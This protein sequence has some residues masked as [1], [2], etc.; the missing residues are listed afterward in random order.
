MH[1][2]VCTCVC[3]CMSAC[4]CICVCAR[5]YVC[6]CICFCVRILMSASHRAP[7]LHVNATC[8]FTVLL[9][10]LTS[11]CYSPSLS[12]RA[13]ALAYLTM[14]KHQLAQKGLYEGPHAAGAPRTVE[15]HA[16]G[17]EGPHAA[18]AP[19]AVGLVFSPQ[20][21]FVDDECHQ[22]VTIQPA[23]RTNRGQWTVAPCHPFMHTTR[24]R[25]GPPRAGQGGHE[26]CAAMCRS[27]GH[28]GCAATCRSGGACEVGRHVQVRRGMWGVGEA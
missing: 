28:E 13:S 11:L 15:P 24:T 5:M 19:R 14:L 8:C 2:G 6:V 21:L 1:V 10:W 17:A 3:N 12:H 4:A 26:G 22:G 9:P 20:H 25:S 27:G 18:G 7:A 16:A 23:N